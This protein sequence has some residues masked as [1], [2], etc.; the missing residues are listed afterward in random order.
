MKILSQ[1]RSLKRQ[2]IELQ[3]NQKEKEFKGIPSCSGMA[4][5]E[6]DPVQVIGL[7][8]MEIEKLYAQLIEVQAD[9]IKAKNRLDENSY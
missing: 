5:T 3:Q 7:L 9:C 8:E 1:L 2:V 4:I 6:I